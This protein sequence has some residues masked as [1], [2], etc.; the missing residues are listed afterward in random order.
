[1]SSILRAL[2]KLEEETPPEEKGVFPTDTSI[3]DGPKARDSGIGSKKHMIYLGIGSLSLVIAFVALMAALSIGPFGGREVRVSTGPDAHPIDGS[4][5]RST[6]TP[7]GAVQ[8]APPGSPP[9]ASGSHQK[10][11]MV[12]PGPASVTAQPPAKASR[13]PSGPPTPSVSQ[14]RN[15]K[16]SGKPSTR[17]S[18]TSSSEKVSRPTA[19][20][21]SSRWP[22]VRTTPSP[23]KPPTE[24][25]RS[26]RPSDSSGV[27]PPLLSST[28]LKLQ[29]ISWAEAPKQ[30][31]AVI[32]GEILN[33]GEQISG[34]MLVNI[35]VNDVILQQDGIMWRM[36]FS[37]K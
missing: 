4:G 13:P 34:F 35:R 12:S 20:A 15:A 22:D 7:S 19:K 32:N 30:R 8:G 16:T 14:L 26:P 29:A 3:P 28:D 10:G 18:A 31:I 1:M 36:E 37:P 33:I 21:R 25:E 5:K 2:K 11:A 17:P 24:P 6:A 9:P 23:E 27:D